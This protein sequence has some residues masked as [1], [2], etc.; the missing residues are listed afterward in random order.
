MKTKAQEKEQA[1]RLRSEG[2]SVN[3]IAKELGVAKSSV[4]VWVRE[5]VLTQEQ[6]DRINKLSPRFPD[7][8]AKANRQRAFEQRSEYQSKGADKCDNASLLFIAGCMLYWGEGGKNRNA[9]RLANSDPALLKL[10]LQFLRLE[11]NI[12]DDEITLRLVCYSNNGLSVEEMRDFWLNSLNLPI[13][14]MRQIV[15]DRFPTSSSKASRKKGKLPYG[16]ME[17]VVGRTDVVQQIFGA[18]Q[19]FGDFK[20]ESWIW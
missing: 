10:F 5:I 17:L 19:K 18:I 14:C 2:K 3:E 1:I 20:R 8:R 7:L 6:K 4:S 16:T 9:V 12:K 15:V 13:S 11:F